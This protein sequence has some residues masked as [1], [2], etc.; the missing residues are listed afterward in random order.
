MKRTK[1]I[2]SWAVVVVVVALLFGGCGDDSE[3]PAADASPSASQSSPTESPS[4]SASPVETESCRTGMQ[5]L[6]DIMLAN[7]E[8]SLEF[9]VFENRHEQLKAGIDAGLAP[10]S[11][12]VNDPAREVMYQF[13]LAYARWLTCEKGPCV[14][15]ITEAL[16]TGVDKAGEVQ[17]ALDATA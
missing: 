1:R 9:N 4:E 7:K 13:A 8:P 14:D 10:C 3:E 11:S 6:V 15:V 12:A 5:P 16:R 2:G 17:D